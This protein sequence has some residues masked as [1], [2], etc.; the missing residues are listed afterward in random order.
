MVSTEVTAAVGAARHAQDVAELCNGY[1]AAPVIEALG[2][3][4][5][6]IRSDEVMSVAE[7]VAQLEVIDRER[8]RIVD[9]SLEH[10]RRTI[11]RIHAA[12]GNLRDLT[13]SGDLLAAAPDELRRTCG[14]TCV[15]VSRIIGSRWVPE[16]LSSAE[17]EQVPAYFL[18]YV[19]GADI[20]LAHM[21]LETE[22]VRRS[23][24]VFVADPQTDPRVHQ[25]MAFASQ[26]SGYASAPII[27]NRRAIGFFHVDRQG[28]EQS[29]TAEDRDNLWVFT[30]HFS[31]L[32]ER[33]VLAER[34]EAQRTQLRAA[35]LAAVDAVDQV[36]V[37][38]IRLAH[39]ERVAARFTRPGA[40]GRVGPLTARERQVLEMMAAGAS[41]ADVARAL[42]LSEGTVKTHVHHIL[43][44]LRAANRAQA[45]A[46]YVQEMRAEAR[47]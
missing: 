23:K 47:S 5:S 34:L 29:V 22:M 13:G 33:A 44:K 41:N 15:M 7:R 39:Y 19:E 20:P 40:V 6:R 9:G 11:T 14:F 21:L 18:A 31:L 8:H 43:R 30:E 2:D 37:E 38:D 1:V 45:V 35:L 12:F 28:Q 42:V 36:C 4:R 25:G 17:P 32:F 27:S 26:T 24:P 3:L 46:R 10:R 16:A